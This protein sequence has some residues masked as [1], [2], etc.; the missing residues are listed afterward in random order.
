[1]G[2]ERKEEEDIKGGGKQD[3]RNLYQF[4]SKSFRAFYGL[5]VPVLWPSNNDAVESLKLRN[6]HMIQANRTSG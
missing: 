6:F 5:K 3:A 4:D 1:M 2:K